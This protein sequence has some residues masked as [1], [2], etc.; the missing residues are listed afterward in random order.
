MTDELFDFDRDGIRILSPNIDR[1]PPMFMPGYAASHC[2][3]SFRAG[4]TELGPQTQILTGLSVPAEG[5][6]DR[7]LRGIVALTGGFCRVAIHHNGD[8]RSCRRAAGIKKKKTG[9]GPRTQTKL[10]KGRGRRLSPRFVR[11]RHGFPVP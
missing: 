9:A 5:V 6:V 8:A 7:I 4:W 1:G 10:I 2:H 3:G 11:R